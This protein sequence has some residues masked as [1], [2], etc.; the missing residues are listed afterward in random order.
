M[1][2]AKNR[3]EYIGRACVARAYAILHA[4]RYL[5]GGARIERLRQPQHRGGQESVIVRRNNVTGVFVQTLDA[6]SFVAD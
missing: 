5:S 6:R 3:E 2:E 1:V 4:Y